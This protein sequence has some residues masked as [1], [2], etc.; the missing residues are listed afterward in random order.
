VVAIEATALVPADCEA[1]FELLSDLGNHW[2]L[3]SC[4]VD[5]IDLDSSRPGGV[6]DRATVRLRGPLGVSRTVRTKVTAARSPRLLI[7]TAEIG[8]R[9]H[10]RVSWTL[11][12]RLNETRVRLS[13]EVDGAGPA[14]RA[15]LAL[16][17]RRWLE[18]RFTQTLDA[19]VEEMSTAAS[20]ATEHSA[21]DV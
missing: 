13:A 5:V 21:A 8:S 15:M 1:V 9:T 19:L 3:A 10:A 17:G 7:G 14:D 16:G 11:A 6:P 20:V 18:R 2:R 4:F 12:R